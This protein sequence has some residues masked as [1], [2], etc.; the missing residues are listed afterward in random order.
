ML[1]ALRADGYRAWDV[2]I[3]R[4][5]ALTENLKLSF[6]MD[7]LNATNHTNFGPTSTNPT[8]RNFGKVTE[9]FGLSRILQFNLRADF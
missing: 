7:A 2:K 8:D 9:Q 1:D 6:S 3:L 5:F 4:R